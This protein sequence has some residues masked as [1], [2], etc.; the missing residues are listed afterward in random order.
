M[1]FVLQNERYYNIAIYNLQ[2]SLVFYQ[3]NVES[4]TTMDILSRPSGIYI[5]YISIGKS[6]QEWKIIKE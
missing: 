3:K 1:F 2:G 6:H 4:Y 5:I